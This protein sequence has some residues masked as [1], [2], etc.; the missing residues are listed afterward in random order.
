MKSKLSMLLYL[1]V[2]QMGILA[3]KSI[4]QKTRVDIDA[5]PSTTIYARKKIDTL[6][7]G[8]IR[9]FHVQQ[10]DVDEAGKLYIS[11]YGN[12]RIVVL[13]SSGRFVKLFGGKGEG[14]GEFKSPYD[15]KVTKDRIY[16][17][18]FANA[19][20]QIFDK[21]YRYISTFPVHPTFF[22]NIA[23]DPDDRFI[24]VPNYYKAPDPGC[25]SIFDGKK[26]F[27]FRKSILQLPT[28]SYHKNAPPGAL[29][30]FAMDCDP[31]GHLYVIDL[32]FPFLYKLNAEGELLWRVEFEG[33]FA[34]NLKKKVTKKISGSGGYVVKSFCQDLFVDDDNN[35]L[36]LLG[37]QQ[38]LSY[39]A[40]STKWQRIL[41]FPNEQT[42]ENE[43][44]YQSLAK[45]Q[46]KLYISDSITETIYVYRLEH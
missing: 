46:D 16:V 5:L 19:R 18:E 13:D 35:I 44:W 26:P 7:N 15:V 30:E 43:I 17:S 27:R 32:P 28:H 40:H 21:Q 6:L 22:F 4:L 36:I 24:Y 41:A 39:D 2:I 37:N 11:D 14:P 1:F 33:K 29:Y 20:I 42:N 10:L 31:D 3:S 12:N 34:N 9:F 23:V 25:V 8:A 38:I 45:F